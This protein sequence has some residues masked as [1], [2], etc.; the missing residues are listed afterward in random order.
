MA[1]KVVICA[2]FT[3]ETAPCGTMRVKISPRRHFAGSQK[4]AKTCTP[5]AKCYTTHT[6]LTQALYMVKYQQKDKDY[7]PQLTKN[8]VLPQSKLHNSMCCNGMHVR[9]THASS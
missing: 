9:A 4:A 5:S 6:L 2:M 8:S 1:A 7:H 3:K